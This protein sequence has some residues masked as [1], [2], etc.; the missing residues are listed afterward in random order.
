MAGGVYGEM[1]PQPLLPASMWVFFSFVQNGGATQLVLGFFHEEIVPYVAVDSVC[2][3][4]EVSSGS[5]YVTTLNQ[6][7][8]IHLELLT[9]PGSSCEMLG[10]QGHLL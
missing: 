6:K 10:T 4:E 1:V 7:L 8:F 9:S 5:R 2:L 3:C